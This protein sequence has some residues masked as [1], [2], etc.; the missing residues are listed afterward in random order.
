MSRFAATLRRL[1]LLFIFIFALI[2]IASLGA[3]SASPAGPPSGSISGRITAP[4]GV[5][6]ANAYVYAMTT[7]FQF[8][9]GTD[10]A[11]DGTYSIQYL[12]TDSYVVHAR[13]DGYGWLHYVDACD[14][15]GVVP[16]TVESFY[17][18]PNINITLRP[19]SVATGRVLAADGVTPLAGITVDIFPSAG[20]QIRRTTTGADGR[21][22]VG[23]LSNCE[24]VA[25]A[26]GDGYLTEYYEEAP[27]RGDATPFTVT[28]PNP[29][30]GLDFT[31]SP[32]TLLSG[33]VIA[34]DTRAQ[35]P[36][37]SV[38]IFNSE[39]S[40]W[41]RTDSNGN[42]VI[43]LPPGSYQVRANF[44]PEGGYADSRWIPGQGG[45]WLF[46]PQTVPVTGLEIVLPPAAFLNFSAYGEDGI[47]KINGTLWGF[48]AVPLEF[49]RAAGFPGLNFSL[50]PV[51]A[52]REIYLFFDTFPLDPVGRD[53]E[54]TWY[55]D[56]GATS[57]AATATPLRLSKGEFK[58]IEIQLRNISRAPVTPADGGEVLLENSV[59]TTL[60]LPPGAIIEDAE[61]SIRTAPVSGVPAPLASF[62]DA[63]E[64][65]TVS[66]TDEFITNFASPFTIKVIYEDHNVPKGIEE[67]ELALYYFAELP[68][69]NYGWI[70]IPTTIDTENNILTAEYDRM[71]NYFQVMAPLQGV[72][73]PVISHLP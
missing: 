19:E 45:S 55:S 7:N 5:P 70:K 21:Y 40:Y 63:F 56:R 59:L 57:S 72:F 47:T 49:Q 31:L 28:Q 67:S 25:S 18:T 42:F 2:G 10:A 65:S 46:V 35:L 62:T 64:P 38:N 50:V 8:V 66:N 26:F 24:Y 13:A 61:L 15:S 3:A 36:D 52:N 30:A 14:D 51:A 23:G 44:P 17:D 71:G 33:S 48:V 12:D 9:A 54:S 4:G 6:I 68:S 73:L 58:D 16:V 69:N 39:G 32:G 60:T 22:T 1:A 41:L 53:Y 29:V 37:I 34:E 27:S 43:T 20:G 11:P